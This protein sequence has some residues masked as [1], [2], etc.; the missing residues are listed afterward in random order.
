MFTIVETESFE[1]TCPCYW[2][3]QEYDE[4]LTFITE[5]PSTG[6]VVRSSG[7]MRK[8]RWSIGIYISF[9]FKF[10]CLMKNLCFYSRKRSANLGFHS[11]FLA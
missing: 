6:D 9:Y 8:V 7:G 5:N 1:H 11:K 10:S 2:T 3:E 4:F